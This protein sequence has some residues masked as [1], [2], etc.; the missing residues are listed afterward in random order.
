MLADMNFSALTSSFTGFLGPA[1]P[2]IVF[3]VIWRI[4]KL[5]KLALMLGIVAGAI[6]LFLVLHH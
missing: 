5:I 1:L 4:F 3:L 2:V 6:G